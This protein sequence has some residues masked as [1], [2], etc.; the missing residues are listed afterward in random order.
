MDTRAIVAT[1]PIGNLPVDIVLEI[2]KHVRRM[3]RMAAHA[4][5]T[6]KHFILNAGLITW[7]TVERW[8]VSPN[9]FIQQRRIGWQARRYPPWTETETRLWQRRA[10][11]EALSP[12]M[13]EFV[14]VFNRPYV[15]FD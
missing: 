3:A 13:L 11:K 14:D 9:R 7:L 8:D 15:S 10:D 12:S 4:R 2:W 5:N 1:G 6:L